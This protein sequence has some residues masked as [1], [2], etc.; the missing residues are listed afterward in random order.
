MSNIKLKYI[1]HYR[2]RLGVHRYYFNRRGCPATALPGEP[3][4]RLFMA[5]YAACMDEAEVRLGKP[6]KGP[7]R[8]IEGS[9]ADLAHRYY[10]SA[11]YRTLAP[12]TRATYRNEIERIIKDHGDKL[13]ANLTRR[14]VK[15]LMGMKSDTPGAANKLLRTLR[16]LMGVAI[17]EEMRTD[18]PT[19]KMKRLKVPGDGFVS[20]SE[21]DIRKFEARHAAGTKARLA[22][23]LLLYTGQRRGDVVKLGP[24]NVVGDRMNLTQG[25]TGTAMLIPIHP[26]LKSTL[27]TAPAGKPA[28]LM[29]EHGKP[30]AAA[31]FGNWFRDR[32]AEAGLPLGYNAHGLRKAAARRL[33]DAGCTPHE[34]MAITGHKSISEVKRYTDKADQVRLAHSALA[35]LDVA[36][37]AGENAVP[38]H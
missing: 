6:R 34:I 30:F 4:S 3:G 23:D 32:C 21:D 13:V 2:D 12:I 25:K 24:K 20:W 19:A 9:F 5:T 18:D 10:A 38:T 7:R 15:V 37:N 11:Q 26:R 16:M 31:G 36:S 1:K 35:K 28:F 17:E 29:T 8:V 22:F 27:K 33:A 14:D